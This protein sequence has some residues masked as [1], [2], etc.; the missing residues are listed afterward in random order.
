MAAADLAATSPSKPAMV[1]RRIATA[2]SQLPLST[3]NAS[4][5]IGRKRRKAKPTSCRR[6]AARARGLI[7]AGPI[8]K[9]KRLAKHF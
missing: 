5:A 4:G 1:E 2:G 6:Q 8:D 9:A 7:D 3:R